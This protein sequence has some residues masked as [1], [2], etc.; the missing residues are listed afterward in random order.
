MTGYRHGLIAIVCLALVACQ[1]PA[2]AETDS[3]LVKKG[4]GLVMQNCS[5]CHA[6]GRTGLSAHPKAPLFRHLGR[7]Y[8]LDFFVEGLVEGFSTGHPDMPEFVFEVDDAI[9]I[10]A[11]LKSVQER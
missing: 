1:P 6:T 3:T 8:N 9:A 2:F 7:R 10:V 5:R 4:E 11:Y